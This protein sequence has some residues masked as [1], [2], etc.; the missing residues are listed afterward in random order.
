MT[1]RYSRFQRA[2][3]RIGDLIGKLLLV[4]ILLAS[5]DIVGVVE[6][7]EACGGD[8]V[9]EL[10]PGTAVIVEDGRIEIVGV[11]VWRCVPRPQ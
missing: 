11:P 2:L 8:A 1:Y 9:P 6:A 3:W 10:N 4:L 7:T 5:T